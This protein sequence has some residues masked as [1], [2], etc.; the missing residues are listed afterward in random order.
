MTEGM[1][2]RKW[3]ARVPSVAIPVSVSVAVTVPVAVSF[4]SRVSIPFTISVTI[5]V[6]VLFLVEVI[7]D[8]HVNIHNKVRPGTG[9]WTLQG[10]VKKK[11][12]VIQA[13]LAKIKLGIMS[14]T[15]QRDLMLQYSSLFPK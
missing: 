13:P 9:V 5:I 15:Y 11:Y 2:T 12:C 8:L 14:S 4:A 10:R 7:F 6:S 1:I 3:H